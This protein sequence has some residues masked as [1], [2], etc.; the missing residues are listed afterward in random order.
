MADA[1]I[2]SKRPREETA[3][4]PLDT[5]SPAVQAQ[6]LA[7]VP[8]RDIL[9]PYHLLRPTKAEKAAAKAEYEAH[10]DEPGYLR[11][12]L[13]WNKHR[14]LFCAELKVNSFFYVAVHT[15]SWPAADTAAKI[16][17]AWRARN[18]C[19]RELNRQSK[20]QKTMNHTD[21]IAADKATYGDNPALERRVLLVMKAFLVQ[22]FRDKYGL[23][24]HFYCMPDGT[25]ADALFGVDGMPEGMWL[26][27]QLK[28]T[29]KL[30]ELA[31]ERYSSG[32][33]H[34]WEFAQ[35]KS[36]KGMLV[37]CVCEADK[38]VW[39]FTGDVLDERKSKFISITRSAETGEPLPAPETDVLPTIGY[40]AL[41]KRMR[42]M[43]AH[44]V[45]HGDAKAPFVLT[46]REA[47]E[48][49][50]GANSVIE[51]VG[52]RAHNAAVYG[53]PVPYEAAVL[54]GIGVDPLQH[55]LLQH[56][57]G[58]RHVITWPD[59]QNTK[60]DQM[61][62]DAQETPFAQWETQRKQYK[63]VHKYP[64]GKTGFKVH[65][66]TLMYHDVDSKPIYA[67]QYRLG[68]N[69]HYIGIYTPE[70]TG[71]GK[72]IAA[73]T[74]QGMPMPTLHELHVW[75]IPEQ[76]MF[77]H[78]LL[79]NGDDNGKGGFTAHMSDGFKN[80]N[81]G[82][83]KGVGNTPCASAW[84]QQYHRCYKRRAGAWVQV[85]DEKE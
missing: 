59:G 84:T 85:L 1:A 66:Q 71:R 19:Q 62:W 55:R 46:T 14:S 20:K 42:E 5:V 67:N 17:A 44:V 13:G 72:A 15:S 65:L 23:A 18:P 37:V 79:K 73:K 11:T 41:A 80:L 81:G 53:K 12:Y 40:K 31:D 83:P 3:A 38:H 49:V 21:K 58:S 74:Q 69:T 7:D 26:Q 45:K 78:G 54:K 76:A 47:A 68:D 9:A 2:S 63:T 24:L 25:L 39:T 8:L 77:D 82:L 52:I 6:I 43:C 36:Y 4:N 70:I 33:L 27:L 30:R 35:T 29:K 50:L 60:T 22:R 57:G 64:K 48:N 28:T 34:R 32:F 16:C 51:Y 56:S 61:V 10:K 75:T